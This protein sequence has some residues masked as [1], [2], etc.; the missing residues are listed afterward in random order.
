[1]FTVVSGVLISAWYYMEK[2]PPPKRLEQQSFT[3]TGSIHRNTTDRIVRVI[4]LFL[5][6]FLLYHTHTHTHS[7]GV[8]WIKIHP[9]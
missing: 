6:S 7:D 5:Y 4:H 9:R 8:N 2:N 3:N 1:M